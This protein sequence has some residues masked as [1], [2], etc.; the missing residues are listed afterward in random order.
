MFRYI[1]FFALFA[2]SFSAQSGTMNFK[3]QVSLTILPSPCYTTSNHLNVNV[4]CGTSKNTVMT[5]IE[6]NIAFNKQNQT[7][8]TSEYIVT[9][10]Y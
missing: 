2:S 10:T 4:E 7:N 3:I 5:S 1:L 6:K 8:N 9:I